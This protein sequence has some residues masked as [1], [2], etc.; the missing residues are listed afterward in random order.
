MQDRRDSGLVLFSPLPPSLP[1]C[2]ERSGTTMNSEIYINMERNLTCTEC[3]Q[4]LVRFL[5]D[6]ERYYVHTEFF[7]CSP[8]SHHVRF[9]SLL[10][11]VAITESTCMLLNLHEEICTAH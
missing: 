10:F 7:F 6:T 4:S 9:F 2:H 5:E 8:V 11:A 3:S 1:S